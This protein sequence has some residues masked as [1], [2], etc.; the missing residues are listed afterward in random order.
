MRIFNER[1]IV[2]AFE[3]WRYGESTKRVPMKDVFEAGFEAGVAAE[4]RRCATACVDHTIC[5]ECCPK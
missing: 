4:R 3:R 1:F 2:A 5:A